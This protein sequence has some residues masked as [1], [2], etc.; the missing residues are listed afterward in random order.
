MDFDKTKGIGLIFFISFVLP[1]FTFGSLCIFG[2]YS[3]TFC[4][5]VSLIA[6]MVTAR[7]K[8]PV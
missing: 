6:E 3:L 2:I 1:I 7:G 4:I 5:L 8:S